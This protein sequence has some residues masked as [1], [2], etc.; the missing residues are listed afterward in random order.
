MSLIYLEVGVENV[1]GGRRW[2]RG[3]ILEMGE[4]DWGQRVSEDKGYCGFNNKYSN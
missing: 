4:G 3:A 2:A 1:G